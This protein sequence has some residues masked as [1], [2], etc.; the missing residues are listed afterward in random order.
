ME[1]VYVLS[2]QLPL[3][4]DT[5]YK[6]RTKKSRMIMV[7]SLTISAKY[8]ILDVWQGSNTTLGRAL[9]KVGNNFN[10]KS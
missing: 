1:Y 3:H 9:S 6:T 2:K 5:T 8:S 7:N 10:G 4:N